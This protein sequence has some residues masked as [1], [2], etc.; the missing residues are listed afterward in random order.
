MSDQHKQRAAPRPSIVPG[1]KDSID[2]DSI[3]ANLAPTEAVARPARPERA[4]RQKLP[5]TR[6]GRY[7][8]EKQIGKGGMGAVYLAHDEE[9]DRRVALKVPRFEA[10]GSDVKERFYREAR[11]AAAVEHPNICP[12][13]DVGEH[14]GVAYLTMAFIEGK[15]LS[16]Y[17]QPGKAPRQKHVAAVV[18]KVALALAAAHA[19]GVVH[20]DLKPANIMLSPGKG[21]IVMDFGLALR[22]ATGDARLTRTGIVMG[23]PMYMSPEQVSG[24]PS[25]VGPSSDIYS[26]AVILYELLAGRPP[27]VGSLAEILG[28]IAVSEPQPPSQFRPGLDRE[29]EA[30]CL[31]G[32]ARAPA[33]RFASMN[34]F[35]QA[36]DEYVKKEASPPPLP[37]S[38]AATVAIP[39]HQA[40][41][42]ETG[43]HPAESLFAAMAETPAHGET[44]P[45]T[46]VAT[47][48]QIAPPTRPVLFKRG[49]SGWPIAIAGAAAMGAIV[50]LGITL[51]V[52]T[53]TG[54]IQ[55]E[56]SD[57]GAK[58]E[59]KVDGEKVRLSGIGDP[60]ELTVGKHHLLVAGKDF[61]TVS[62]SFTV[63]K[64]GNPV[65]RVSLKPIEPDGDPEE[66]RGPPPVV[67][68]GDGQ[69]PPI[70]RGTGAP[71]SDRPPNVPAATSVGW[72]DVNPKNSPSWRWD[73]QNKNRVY[74]T[75][76]DG[77]LTLDNGGVDFPGFKSKNLIMRAQLKFIGG[78]G[79][80]GLQVRG[81]YAFVRKENNVA[82]FGIG[83]TQK[84]GQFRNLA[85]FRRNDIYPDFFEMEFAAIDDKL[86]VKINGDKV[87]ETRPITDDPGSGLNAFGAKGMF[88]NVQVRWP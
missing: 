5:V 26:L 39:R 65:L 56:L 27:F 19:Q 47:I 41:R 18:R 50:I 58:V 42:E 88:K 31:K 1:G 10:P 17:I 8:I 84:N 75:Y 64:D 45:Q 28:H 46:M 37:K 7:R 63:R 6:I 40:K 36:L 25:A 20:R 83:S 35:A 30:I 73:S 87:L 70:S 77:V 74:K 80:M 59:V 53:P 69:A 52:R 12:I 33:D 4:D 49:R 81:H 55:I 61:E 24:D 86:T 2:S 57:P 11:A 9:L 34:E 82:H 15:P 66:R 21:P 29:L 51:L 16:E 76:Q 54:L 79:N 48:P 13:Y 62:E 3:A 32:M 60:L 85:A 23:T 43:G 14:D 78:S 67:A 72:V 38:A 22:Q 68:Q 44:R 71:T